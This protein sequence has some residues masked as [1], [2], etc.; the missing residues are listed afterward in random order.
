MRFFQGSCSGA[1]RQGSTYMKLEALLASPK[2]CLNSVIQN[3]QFN[4]IL[5]GTLP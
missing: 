5:N 4:C 1:C 3:N 2:L